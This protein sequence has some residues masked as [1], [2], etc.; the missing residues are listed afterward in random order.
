MEDL[1]RTHQTEFHEKA[2]IVKA[3]VAASPHHRIQF[4]DD[5]RKLLVSWFWS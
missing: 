4:I 5:I 1:R 2:K 3:N